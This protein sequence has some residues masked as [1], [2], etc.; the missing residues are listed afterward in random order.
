METKSQRSGT[1]KREKNGEKSGRRKKKKKTGQRSLQWWQQPG[2]HTLPGQAWRKAPLFRREV[3]R[4]EARPA[5]S[6]LTL[7]SSQI[8]S[9]GPN[10]ARL[11]LRP[12]ILP[13]L[14]PASRSTQQPRKDCSLPRVVPK[15]QRSHMWGR[16]VLGS[17][18]GPPGCPCCW[19]LAACPGGSLTVQFGGQI[20]HAAGP[21]TKA[22]AKKVT[23]AR[24]CCPRR[25]RLTDHAPSCP[26]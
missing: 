13:I 16:A 8:A 12:P 18:N 2:R 26:W 15:H 23:H 4:G 6:P 7:G 19:P 14:L 21:P 10:R 3:S 24:I 20:L 22:W 11:L 25:H 9:Q 5:P 17:S 1:K